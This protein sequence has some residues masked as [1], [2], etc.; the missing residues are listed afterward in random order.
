[1]LHQQHESQQR[2]YKHRGHA[3]TLQLLAMPLA[4]GPLVM[5]V[6]HQVNRMQLGAALVAPRRAAV[7]GRVCRRG[8]IREGIGAAG[9]EVREPLGVEQLRHVCARCS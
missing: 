6:V 8:G 9:L 5:S 3:H 1:M 7:F 2:E 4:P